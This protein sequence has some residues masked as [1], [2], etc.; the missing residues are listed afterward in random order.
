MSI[1]SKAD[2]REL[3]TPSLSTDDIS[4][5]ELDGKI[6]MVED[7]VSAVYFND[8]T[9][10]SANAKYPIIMLVLS[11]IINSHI[12]KKYGIPK[13][14]SI[15]DFKYSLAVGGSNKSATD[16]AR[17]WEDMAIEMLKARGTYHWRIWMAND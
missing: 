17:T 10:S 6:N 11:K 7:Y 5:D 16:V 2:I 4:D 13:S 9:P 8:T 12:I 1:V 3:F 14:V 15:G